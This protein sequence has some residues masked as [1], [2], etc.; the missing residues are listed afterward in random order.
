MIVIIRKKSS[1]IAS[2]K[3]M[4]RSGQNEETM[5]LWPSFFVCIFYLGVLDCFLAGL[6]SFLVALEVFFFALLFDS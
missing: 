6:E 1:G 4:D 2:A 5:V 3:R